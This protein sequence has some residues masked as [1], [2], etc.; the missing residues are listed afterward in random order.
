MS[1]DTMPPIPDPV[2]NRKISEAATMI[3][4]VYS[5]ERLIDRAKYLPPLYEQVEQLTDIQFAS[6]LSIFDK[7]T[8]LVAFATELRCKA[9]MKARTPKRWYN[10]FF[11]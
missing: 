6:V 9:Y 7:H 2:E 5:L 8:S 11:G 10:N 3:R 4:A 1:K